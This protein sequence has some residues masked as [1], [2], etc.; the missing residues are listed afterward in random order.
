LVALLAVTGLRLAEVV[1][2]TNGDLDRS[3]RLLRVQRRKGG[4]REWL[5][6]PRAV[7]DLAEQVEPG[8]RDAKAPLISARGGGFLSIRQAQ[9]RFRQWCDANGL[10]GAGLTPRALRRSFAEHIYRRTGNDLRLTSL[11]LGH[12]HPWT[13]AR[14][15]ALAPPTVEREVRALAEDLCGPTRS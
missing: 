2:L 4:A 9:V 6:A 15:L 11:A 3:R 7:V 8:E 10:A 13:T 14:Y 12:R 1:A 5:P